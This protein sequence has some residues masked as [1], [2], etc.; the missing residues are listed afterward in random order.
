MGDAELILCDLELH[1]SFVLFHLGQSCLELLV[2]LPLDCHL[3]LVLVRL[4]LDNGNHNLKVLIVQRFHRPLHAGD[5][6]SVLF[7][8]LLVL[9]ELVLRIRHQVK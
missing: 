3:L 7:D 9:F 8:K 6:G 4:R 2:L 1:L 5:F